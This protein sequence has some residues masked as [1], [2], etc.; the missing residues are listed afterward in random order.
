[1]TELPLQTVV[2]GAGRLLEYMPDYR[3]AF[4]AAS[5]WA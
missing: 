2:L 1:M 5:K 3:S 4:L